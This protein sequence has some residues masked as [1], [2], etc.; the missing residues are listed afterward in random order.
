MQ[1]TNLFEGH[2]PDSGSLLILSISTQ[3][4]AA[5]V[6]LLT[7]IQIFHMHTDDRRPR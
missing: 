2:L 6:S 1:I 3:A 7:L 5:H 4:I